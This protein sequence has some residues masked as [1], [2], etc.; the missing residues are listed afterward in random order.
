MKYVILTAGVMFPV[1]LVSVFISRKGRGTQTSKLRDH[2]LAI[3]IAGATLIALTAIFDSLMIKADLFYYAEHLISGL[4]IGLAPIEDFAYPVAAVIL[5]PALWRVLTAR[6]V[7]ERA[8]F[9]EL[10]MASRPISWIN[11]AYP[12]AAAMI[13]TTGRI[14]ALLIIGTL[15]YLIPYNLALYGI[16]DVYDYESDQH[17]PR[18][19]SIEGALLRPEIHPTLLGAALITN[20]PFLVVFIYAANWFGLAALAVST[21]ALLAYSLPGLRFKERPIVDSM[22]S[23]AHFVTPAVIGFALAGAEFTTSRVVILTAF[24]LWGMAA[25]A[26]GAVQDVV[27]DRAGG[28]GSVATVFGAAVTVRISLLLWVAAGILMLLTPAPGPWAA[29]I[30]VPYLIN[31]AP[32]FKIKDDA[33]HLTNRAWR[34]FIWINYVCGFLVTMLLIFVART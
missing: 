34:R 13:L 32:Y 11:T 7:A 24:F 8:K 12:F 18:K 26:F 5:L 27:P 2:W 4:R 29:L 1:A 19:D 15:Y 30:V 33:A 17:N 21:F 25:H 22:T 3:L 6:P 16:N 20:L 14:D 9:R 10:F 23:S 31:C 28:I